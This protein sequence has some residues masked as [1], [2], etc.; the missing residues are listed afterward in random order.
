MLAVRALETRFV[1]R[2]GVVYA[3]NG[4]TFDVGDGE[5]V[6]IVGESGSGKSVSANS[7]LGLIRPP[8]R[9]IAGSATFEGVDLIALS[10]RQLRRIRGARIGYIAQ[11]PFG[12]LNPLLTIGAQFGNVMRAHRRAD[13]A[14]IRRQ[15]LAM[16]QRVGI[17][18]PER[19]LDGY[20]H[21]LS[22]GMAQRVVIALALLLNPSLVVADEPTTALDVTVQRQILDLI[23]G[24]V[25]EGN[26]S[27]LIVTHD[28]GVVAHY[29][30][31]VV[32]MYSGRVVEQGPVEEVFSRPLHPYTLALLRAVPRRGTVVQGLGGRVPDLLSRPTGCS[33]RHR[34]T[35]AFAECS[36]NT[37]NLK[38]LTAGRTIACHLD[39]EREVPAL[40]S[41]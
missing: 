13:R 17:A 38:P 32:V 40:A 39:V 20:A 18:G 19:V 31:R 35:F 34:C 22:G 27:M 23:A 4:V 33:F 11:N 9:V 2:Q 6:G 8:G 36:T 15:A 7:I 28:L 5:V 21:E 16:L 1:T 26:R 29:C 10:Q 14:T 41:G 3:A 12:A 25:E 24:L 37:P 30:D